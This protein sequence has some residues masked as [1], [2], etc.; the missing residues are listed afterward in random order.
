MLA[1]IVRLTGLYL[2]KVLG[3]AWALPRETKVLSAA[4][5]EDFMF[6]D[7]KMICNSVDLSG[8]QSD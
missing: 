7:E 3:P 2:A 6:A 4:I 1:D 8:N 5:P